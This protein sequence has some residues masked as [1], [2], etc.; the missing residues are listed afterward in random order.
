M[1]DLNRPKVRVIAL[2]KNGQPSGQNGEERHSRLQRQMVILMGLLWMLAFVT[3]CSRS[4]KNCS[5]YDGVRLEVATTAH[6][7]AVQN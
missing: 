4:S 5:A 3:G 7:K 6:P 1:Q 2:G